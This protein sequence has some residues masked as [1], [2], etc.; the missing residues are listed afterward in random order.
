MFCF[1]LETYLKAR[2]ERA[3]KIGASNQPCTSRCATTTS[4]EIAE[5]TKA[6]EERIAKMITE[7]LIVDS[8]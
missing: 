2:E 4:N 1:Q 3:V 6:Q 8:Q 7:D 5:M